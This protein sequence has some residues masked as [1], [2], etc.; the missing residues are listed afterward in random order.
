MIQG[1]SRCNTCRK[2]L[3]KGQTD[4]KI[5]LLKKNKLNLCQLVGSRHKCT[6]L[7][8]LKGRLNLTDTSSTE[9]QR[10]KMLLLKRLTLYR[11]TEC[12][13]ADACKLL[14][15][16]TEWQGANACRILLL[17]KERLNLSQIKKCRYKDACKMVLLKRQ[18]ESKPIRVVQRC[19]ACNLAKCQTESIPIHGTQLTESKLLVTTEEPLDY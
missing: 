17:E 9:V 5:L 7:I 10:L 3:L 15:W 4:S 16:Y 8:L 19:S 12:R 14:L 6:L 18:T 1:V 13:N 2:I 11:Y